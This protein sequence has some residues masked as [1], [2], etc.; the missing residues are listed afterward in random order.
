[1]GIQDWIVIRLLFAAPI[2]IAA[3]APAWSQTTPCSLVAE[4]KSWAK[5]V[6]VDTLTLTYL[7]IAVFDRQ[8]EALFVSEQH[9]PIKMRYWR[10]RST[11]TIPT[12]APEVL[13][14]S[15]VYHVDH[16]TSNYGVQTSFIPAREDSALGLNIEFSADT[17]G[18]Y[19]KT[20]KIDHAVRS[21]ESGLKISRAP[22]SAINGH[23]LFKVSTDTDRIWHGGF[24]SGGITGATFI[25]NGKTWTL[26]QGEGVC[27]SGGWQEERVSRDTFAI[28]NDLDYYKRDSLK[29]GKYQYR[30]T[31]SSNVRAS[32]LHGQRF[33]LRKP[34][35][36][37][38]L[39]STELRHDFT[40]K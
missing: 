18:V 31:L 36:C 37:E 21:A 15:V 24:L 5:P 17:S 25:L 10:S 9:G 16:D 32:L 14:V 39:M 12:R 3:N 13:T 6:D 2:L 4:L 27:V 19:L 40:M 1:M 38:E 30:V 11:F 34:V 23:P 26:H 28:V 33:R 29:P 20:L 7:K 8:G 35:R 22:G